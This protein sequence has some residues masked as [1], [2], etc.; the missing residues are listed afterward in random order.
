MSKSNR[1]MLRWLE[2]SKKNNVWTKTTKISWEND[3]T[4]HMCKYELQIL[5]SSHRQCN[6]SV[7]LEYRLYDNLEHQ[8]GC[9]PGSNQY[10]LW[11][12]AE[13]GQADTWSND[14]V[15]EEG[16]YLGAQ[17]Q[18]MSRSPNWFLPWWDSAYYAASVALG[19]TSKATFFYWVQNV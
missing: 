15:W 11:Y 4:L 12:S 16:P 1:Q 7:R 13:P 14:W 5:S 2:R 10:L 19:I 6:L 9:M 8:V 17:L 3:C 18:I